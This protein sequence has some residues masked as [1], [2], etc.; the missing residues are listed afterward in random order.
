MTAPAQGDDEGSR[1]LSR[2][3]EVLSRTDRSEMNVLPRTLRARSKLFFS[4]RAS[5]RCCSLGSM[6]LSPGFAS[7]IPIAVTFEVSLSTSGSSSHFPIS[8]A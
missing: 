8:I 2:I 7:T 6:L 3:K 1:L 5:E 4:Y